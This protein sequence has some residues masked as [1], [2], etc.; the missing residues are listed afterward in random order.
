[1]KLRK[2]TDNDS[3][4]KSILCYGEPKI[5][6]TTA[7]ESMPKPIL[8]LH[9]DGEYDGEAVI[10]SDSDTMSL[11]IITYEDLYKAVMAILLATDSHRAHTK[12]EPALARI[13]IAKDSGDAEEIKELSQTIK[14]HG[15][16]SLVIDSFMSM[17]D[18]FYAYTKQNNTK[19]LNGDGWELFGGIWDITQ[20]MYKRLMWVPM[21]KLY[22][23]HVDTKKDDETGATLHVPLFMGGATYKNLPRQFS[24]I[25]RI[26]QDKAWE[27]GSDH[28]RW[29]QIATSGNFVAGARGEGIGGPTAIPAD[30]SKL[31]E[32]VNKNDKETVTN[33]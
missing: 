18:T 16:Q 13:K 20:Y 22:L 23:T 6:K 21:H 9:M 11:D 24:I 30:F 3:Q 28:N 27:K 5:G 31:I 32:L 8:R 10:S 25:T 15:F 7:S 33:E 19:A 14:E 26:F 1:M 2:A 17:Q 12:D 4:W 29:L